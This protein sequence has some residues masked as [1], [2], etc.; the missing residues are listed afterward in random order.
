[1]V[2][3]EN[4]IVASEDPGMAFVNFALNPGTYQPSG[5]INVSRA[6]EFYIEV[7]SDV[8]GKG[9][10]PARGILITEAC[11]MNFLLIADGSAVL[12]YST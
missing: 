3:G 6:R 7:E 8:I 4:T 10:T 9:S 11:A 5:H 12:R 2:F 1:M